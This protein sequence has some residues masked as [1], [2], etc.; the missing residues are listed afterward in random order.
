MLVGD[1]VFVMSN[2]YEPSACINFSVSNHYLFYQKGKSLSLICGAL[3]WLV[4]SE[5][6]EKAKMEAV[7]SGKLPPSVL[8]EQTHQDVAT[9]NSE[10]SRSTASVNDKCK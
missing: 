4:D 6:R 5:E 3:K 1:Y 9:G 10:G 7:L 8:E 2:I